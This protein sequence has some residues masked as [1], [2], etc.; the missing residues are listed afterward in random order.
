MIVI[1]VHVFGIHVLCEY[2]QRKIATSIY[3]N[4]A[5]SNSI[6]VLLL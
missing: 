1:A 3:G 6:F 2:L 5:P 4:R